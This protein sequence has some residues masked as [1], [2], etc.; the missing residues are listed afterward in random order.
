MAYC[1][2]N[3]FQQDQAGQVPDHPLLSGRYRLDH[4]ALEGAYGLGCRANSRAMNPAG[5]DNGH[6]LDWLYDPVYAYAQ[7]EVEV[8]VING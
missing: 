4:T 7:P 5:S 8:A 2:A 6:L 1:P 3:A